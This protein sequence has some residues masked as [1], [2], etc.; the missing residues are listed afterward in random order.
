MPSVRINDG[1][2]PSGAGVEGG[3][4]RGPDETPAPAREK[5]STVE[6][7]EQDSRKSRHAR[8]KV[9]KDDESA[10]IFYTGKK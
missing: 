7:D 4:K 8:P 5:P 9:G 1:D 6:K 10:D 3:R 2:L